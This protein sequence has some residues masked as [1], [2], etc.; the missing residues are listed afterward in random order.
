M[1]FSYQIAIF[2]ALLVLCGIL[3]L[4]INAD[5]E[6]KTISQLNSEQMVH[7]EQAEQGI[8]RSFSM[9]NSTLSFLAGN[10]NIIG[11]D[12][13]GRLLLREFYT[14]QAD[15]I[16]AVTRVDEHGIILYTYPYESSTGANISSQ[17]HFRKA[18]ETKRTVISDVFMSVQGFRT[19][20]MHVPVFSGKTYRGS[21]AILIPFDRLA[22]KN[23]EPIRIFRGGHAWMVNQQGTILYAPDPRLIGTPAA[24]SPAPDQTVREFL[25]SALQGTQ[26]TGSYTLAGTDP[27]NQPVTFDAVYRPVTINDVTW[28][29]VVATPRG[30]ILSTLQ[31]FQR[32]LLLVSAILIVSLLVF[33]YYISRAWDILQEEEKRRIAESALRES[34][35]TYRSILENMQDVFYRT[36]TNGILT[37]VSPS[38][39]RL[40]KSHFESDLI[41]KPISIFYAN[42]AEWDTIVRTIREKGV[43]TN[44]ETQV[45]QADGTLITVLVTSHAWTDT[46][47]KCMGI[48]G[49]V[50]DITDRKRTENA[51]RQSTKKL[52]LL[53]VITLN[54]IRNA[55]F[56]L[57]GYRELERQAETL[58]ARRE[59]LHQ[60]EAQVLHQIQIWLNIAKNYQDLG[61]NPPRWHTVKT[62]FIYALSHLDPG[63][64]ARKIEVNG[65]E[66]YADPL[67]ENVFFNLTENLIL[68][69]KT[70]TTMT[71]RYEK[72]P[73]G[74]ALIFE[75]NGIGI[76]DDKKAEI[77]RRDST[78]KNGMGLFMVREIL[79]ITG[80]TIRETG[81]YGEG[82]RFE[83][84]I[85]KEGYRF[86]DDKNER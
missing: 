34:E 33:F 73:E 20:A 10:N 74:I 54:D 75:D 58:P 28:T 84:T 14:S 32:D 76:P 62:T 53:T 78:P 67:L 19:I 85:P 30:E 23:L 68:H 22:E 49:I 55:I 12:P 13:H 59:E 18:A 4:S 2:T 15:E 72:R 61:L 1:R 51:L 56:L 5:V 25:K 42:P 43:L 37:M 38:A 45:R 71:L 9:Y 66:I 83:M 48:E 70:A 86:S 47:G 6:S 31:T 7:A 24:A 17:A 82:A 46:E 16:I 44:F 29:I 65:L 3:I 52:S 79:E 40:T 77:F 63:T 36:D 57:S 69:A 35:R 81:T 60:K 39:I 21:L 50:R 27:G 26:G 11:M 80:I 41:G 64:I 8:L